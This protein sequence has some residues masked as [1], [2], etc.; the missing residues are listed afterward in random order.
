MLKREPGERDRQR[1][2]VRAGNGEPPVAGRFVARRPPTAPAAPPGSDYVPPRTWLDVDWREHQRWLTI[3][4]RRVNLIDAGQGEPALVLIHG[5][6]GSWQNW[7]ENMPHLME[8]HRVIALD[9]PGFGYPR[10]PPTSCR[11]RAARA[12]WTTCSA[13][14]ASGPDD[15]GQLDGRLHRRP[16]WRSASPSVRRLLLYRGRVPDGT[17]GRRA[18]PLV[19]RWAGSAAC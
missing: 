15:R 13:S 4:G 16:R 5:L 17:S 8:S 9:L 2:N 10:C 7:L 1:C 11:S 18:R 3:E 14:S 19:S 6:G 12:A